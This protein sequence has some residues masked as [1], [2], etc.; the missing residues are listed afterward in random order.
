MK[1]L[2]ILAVMLVSCVAAYCDSPKAFK[3][4]AYGVGVYNESKG[5]FENIEDTKECSGSGYV[6]LDK[7]VIYL[8]EDAIWQNIL[9]D[10]IKPVYNDGKGHIRWEAKERSEQKNCTVELYN[11]PKGMSFRSDISKGRESYVFDH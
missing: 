10:L 2:I 5:D 11:H 4:I 3:V 9:F 8:N 7:N 6:D 1:R